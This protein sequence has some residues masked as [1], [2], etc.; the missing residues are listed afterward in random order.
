MLRH[1]PALRKTKPKAL[2]RISYTIW[3]PYSFEPG[4]HHKAKQTCLCLPGT[5][6]KGVDDMLGLACLRTFAAALRAVPSVPTLHSPWDTII[7]SLSPGLIACDTHTSLSLEAARWNLP[8]KPANF[9]GSVLHPHLHLCPAP[10]SVPQGPVLL[11][12]SWRQNTCP[13][14]PRLWGASTSCF[15][16]VGSKG[17]LSHPTWLLHSGHQREGP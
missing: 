2:L 16:E 14:L 9:P 12:A 1:L 17:V 6:A 7:P 10:P 3:S 8:L 13:P 5:G 4:S 15:R 11:A